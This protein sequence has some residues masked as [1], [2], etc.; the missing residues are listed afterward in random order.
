MAACR[1]LSESFV[2]LCSLVLLFLLTALT[3]SVPAHAYS[4]LTHEELI[5]LTWKDSIV[6]LLL[7]R[8]PSLTPEQ[9]RFRT[10]HTTYD[11]ATS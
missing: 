9:L 2:G 4:L 3:G 5:D 11:R 8:Y 7:S 1:R 10:S 6:P